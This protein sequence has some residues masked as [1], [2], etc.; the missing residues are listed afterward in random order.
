MMIRL[1]DHRDKTPSF[2]HD[3]VNTIMKI[4]TV[5]ARMTDKR[6]DEPTDTLTVSRRAGVYMKA[7]DV[8]PISFDVSTEV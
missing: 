8:F 5:G 6:S 1:C 2:G 3:H 7:H 4:C